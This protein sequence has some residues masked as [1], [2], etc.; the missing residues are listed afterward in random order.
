VQTARANV[1]PEQFAANVDAVMTR[2]SGGRMTEAEAEQYA[3]YAL[4]ALEDIAISRSPAYS[5]ADA[6]SSL[7]DALSTRS[8]GTRMLVAQILAL[9][10]S[11]AAQR[12]LFD[13]ALAATDDEQV[14]LLKHVADSVRLFGDRAEKRH[15]E[16]LI[17]LI[18]SASGPTAEAAATVHGALNLPTS[19]AVKLIPAP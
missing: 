13:A 4:E 6:E 19:D 14:E 3:I 8:G 18:Q 9:I 5:I 10:D 11:D 7:I 15:V 16:A 12:K 2:A 1:N 17:A